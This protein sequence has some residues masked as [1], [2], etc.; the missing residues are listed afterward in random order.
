MFDELLFSKQFLWEGKS[1]LMHIYRHV[2]GQKRYSH[3]AATT[4]APGDTIISDGRSVEDVL[5][6]QQ[7][8]LPLAILSRSLL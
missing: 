6:K 4:L 8:I 7:H 2:P 5:Q 3:M 1:Y